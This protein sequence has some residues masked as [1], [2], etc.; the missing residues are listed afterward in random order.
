MLSRRR[1]K[2][3]VD[4]L[5]IAAALFVLAVVVRLAWTFTRSQSPESLD[6]GR[7]AV[8]RVIDGDT[9]LLTDGA[10]VR[11]M[12]VDTPE[13]VRPHTPVQP[14]GPEATAFTRAFIGDRPIELRFDRERVDRHGRFL[15][16]VFVDGRMLNEEL[17]RAGLARAEF[18]YHYSDSIKR[19]YRDAQREAQS[20]ARGLWSQQRA[21]DAEQDDLPDDEAVDRQE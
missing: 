13:T 8:A 5:W 16:Y 9:L 20:A 1:F 11:L 3:A 10:R 18:G 2:P 19:R 6:E 14:F 7:H 15:A 4:G 17:V 12:G 21:A